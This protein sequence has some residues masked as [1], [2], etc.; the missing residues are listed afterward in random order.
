[1][2][3]PVQT[4]A[5]RVNQGA[6]GALREAL[7]LIYWYRS[8]FESFVR[9]C[10]DQPEVTSRLNFSE[11]KRIVASQLVSLLSADQERYLPTL[12]RL[13]EEVS[14]FSDFSHLSR[15]EDGKEKAARAKSAVSAL[16]THYDAHAALVA[17]RVSVER[18]RKEEKAKAERRAALTEHLESL[19][20]SYVELLALPSAQ[21]RGYRL[22]HLLSELFSLFDLDPKASF[23]IEGEQIDGAFSFENADYLLEAKWQ[24]DPVEPGDL[25]NFDGVIKSKLKTTLGLFVAINGFTDAAAKTHSR[26]GASMVLM[27]GEDLYAILDGRIGLPEVLHRKRRHASQTGDIYLRVRD[28]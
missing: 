18:R 9:G 23:A 3:E 17:D 1:V 25:R 12:L 20:T 4:T 13:M 10:V 19:R 28:F 8:D 22:Q 2:A 16:K 14:A 24:Q 7:A 27:D 15:L 5:K 21:A 6:L 26:V 11:P